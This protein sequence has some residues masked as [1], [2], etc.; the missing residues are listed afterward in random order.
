MVDNVK[1]GLEPGGNLRIVNPEPNQSGDYVCVV[2]NI[3][4][5][6]SATAKIEI[7]G[8]TLIVKGPQDQTVV[9]GSN[10][11]F[12]CEVSSEI[13]AKGNLERIWYFKVSIQ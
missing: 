7:L 5:E 13:S 4:G 6:A 2:K 1:Y 10:V 9:I 3:H 12:P 11:E 8:K